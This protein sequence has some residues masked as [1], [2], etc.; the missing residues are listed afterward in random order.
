MLYKFSHLPSDFLPTLPSIMDKPQIHFCLHSGGSATRKLP[1]Y[2]SS[3]EAL[4]ATP[5]ENIYLTTE[6]F[7]Y[8]IYFHVVK[9]RIVC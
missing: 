1:K 3:T 8:E 5:K 4:L 6:I 7:F 2:E 9:S